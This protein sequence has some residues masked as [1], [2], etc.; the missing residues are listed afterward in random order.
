METNNQ[1]NG[2]LRHGEGE[3]IV[4]DNSPSCLTKCDFP[5]LWPVTV[6]LAVSWL[7]LGIMANHRISFQLPVVVAIFVVMAAWAICEIRYS[8][9]VSRDKRTMSNTNLKQELLAYKKR[10]LNCSYIIVPIMAGLLIMAFFELKSSFFRSFLFLSDEPEE[11]YSLLF[12]LFLITVV[13]LVIQIVLTF[14]QS[15]NIDMIIEE[16]DK[17]HNS[18][19]N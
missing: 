18:K 13:F 17:Y 10:S 16:I 1:E 7:V 9:L 12:I 2:Q 8:S 19:K 11:F 4:N 3:G 6:F 5:R 15:R 14:H